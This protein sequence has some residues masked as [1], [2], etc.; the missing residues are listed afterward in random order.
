MSEQPISNQQSTISNQESRHT[1]C[2][3]II[4]ASTFVSAMSSGSLV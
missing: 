2:P 4:V 3:S 1:N